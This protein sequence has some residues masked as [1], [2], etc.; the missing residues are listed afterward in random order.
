[1]DSLARVPWVAK[2]R[3]EWTTL[4]TSILGFKSYSENIS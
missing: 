2:K 1:L 4:G 3:S